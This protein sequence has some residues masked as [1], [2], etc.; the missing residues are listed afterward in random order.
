MSGT[1]GGATFKGSGLPKASRI[2]PL[3]TMNVFANVMAIHPKVVVILQSR[4][5]WWT[6]RLTYQ[7]TLK[8][9]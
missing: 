3:G 8:S 9:R 7:R 1:A 6:D 4:L 5:K 2:H